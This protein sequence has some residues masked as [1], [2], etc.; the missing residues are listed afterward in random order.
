MKFVAYLIGILSIPIYFAVL[1]YLFIG[2]LAALV[3]LSDV[4][5]VDLKFVFEVV[6][7]LSFPATVTLS[8]WFGYRT[9]RFLLRRLVL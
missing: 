3:K 5:G 6:A 7:I 2:L 4:F 9:T 8:P 1:V